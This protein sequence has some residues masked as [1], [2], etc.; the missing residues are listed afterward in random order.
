MKFFPY[1]CKSSQRRVLIKHV[2][3]EFVVFAEV[4][5]IFGVEGFYIPLNEV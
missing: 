3:V 4:P 1:S 5:S 2:T